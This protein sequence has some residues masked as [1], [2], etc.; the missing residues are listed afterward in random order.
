[1]R[2]A[3]IAPLYE[4]VPPRAYGGTERV[5]AAL[6]N[7]L[8]KA[9][10]DVTLF[11]SGE[12][13]TDAH[14]AAIVPAPLRE[15]MSRQALI[16]T[17]PH[18]H[19]QMLSEVYRRAD[20]FDLIHAHTDLLTLPFVQL[21][22]TPTVITMHGRL[23][24]DIVSRILPL[25]PEVPLVSISDNQRRVVDHFP[26][27]WIGTAYN[28]L[29]LDQYARQPL[30]KGGH[31]AFVGRLTEEKRPDWAVEVSRRTGIPWRVAA[32]I[33]P[34][35]IAYWEST[36][37]P[38][39]KANEVDYVGEIAEAEKP[40]FFADAAATLFPADWP[41]PF[42]LVIIES[43]AAGTPVIALRRGSIPELLTD[44][45]NGYICDD[46][47]EMIDAVARIDLIDPEAC[48]A[49]ARRFSDKSMT[50]RYLEIYEEVLRIERR[51]VANRTDV[52]SITLQRL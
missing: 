14:L 43:L 41:E 30:N 5:V 2:I 39:F 24:I 44:G 8:C 7:Q 37:E 31:L 32:K 10:H 20:E 51:P 26:L 45:V 47:E 38:L 13:V 17:A 23:D 35:D 21:T 42:G 4:A 1:M 11:A 18:L 9:G 49:S 50:D 46:V 36:I 52:D 34:I 19:L 40:A 48:R 16:D 3:Q 28:G 22:T 29:N 27:R 12:S 33:D 25:Y 15:H 6:C